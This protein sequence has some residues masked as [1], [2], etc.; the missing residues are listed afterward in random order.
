MSSNIFLPTTNILHRVLKI[1]CADSVG[2][3]FVIFKDGNGFLVTAKHVIKSAPART[4]YRHGDG[5]I[6][7]PSSTIKFSTYFDIAVLRLATCEEQPVIQV[8]DFEIGVSTTGLVL[9]QQVMIVGYP[10]GLELKESADI[11]YGRPLPLVKNGFLSNMPIKDECL[12]LDAHVNK[13]F[14]GSPVVARSP[15][16]SDMNRL[17]ICGIQSSMLVDEGFAIAVPIEK[18][19]KL[20]DTM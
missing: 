14:S 15:S 20:I 9:G 13:G 4:F 8:P 17:S 3:G 18:A 11:N 5:W 16:E 19:T 2:T 6:P 7:V 10:L 12:L 1:K